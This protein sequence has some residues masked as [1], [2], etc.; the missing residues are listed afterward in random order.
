M[1]KI[2]LSFVIVGLYV[3]GCTSY[4]CCTPIVISVDQNV[5]ELKGGF[6]NKSFQLDCPL[7]WKLD[8]TNLPPWLQVPNDEGLGSGTATTVTVYA[9]PNA[10]GHREWLLNFIA[11]NGDVIKVLVK[12]TF[13]YKNF[14]ESDLPRW[15]AELSAASANTFVTD[16]AG[17]ILGSNKYTVGREESS[18]GTWFE[19]LEFDNP[20][21]GIKTDASISTQ[22]QDFKSLHSFQILKTE[23][24]ASPKSPNDA[25]LWIVFKEN[26]DSPERFVIQ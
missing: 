10:T 11:S 16:K 17:I 24:G 25:V 7:S 13:E 6:D 20:T 26:A 14:M 2:A 3:A 12:Q 22:I 23:L 19:Y 4:D 8:K 9:T 18:M 5:I 1:K 21:P 15:D